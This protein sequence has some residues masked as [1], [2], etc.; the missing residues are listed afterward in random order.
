MPPT[1]VISPDSFKGSLSARAVAAAIADGWRQV[2]PDDDLVLLP[3][4]DGG[5]GTIDAVESAVAGCR[6]RAVAAVTGPDGRSVPGEWLELPD[7]TAVLEIAQ[8]SGLP[9]MARLDALAATSRGLG[10]V[11]R[12]ALDAGARRMVI[13]LGGSASTDAGLG[14]LGALG[15]LATDEQNEPV[16]DGGGWLHEIVTIDRTHLTAPP[17]DGVTLLT[18]VTAPLTGPHGAAAVFGPQKGA[19]PEQ[20]ALLDAGLGHVARILGG[21]PDAPGAG[22]AGG[23][24]YGLSAAWGAH[25]RP[26]ADYLLELGGVYDAIARADL[27]ITGE[28]SFDEQ[29]LGGKLVGQVLTL[30]GPERTA[31][32]AGRVAARTDAWTASLTALAGSAESAMADT[33]RW[34]KAAGA[35]AAE[36]FSA[37]D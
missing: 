9:L 27:V 20:V 2:R 15:L 23:A 8:A 30:A 12:A 24:A 11:A 6:R 1:I 25:I 35:A 7:G 31:V 13:G 22:A 34:A 33:T 19:T 5:E 17:P 4:A 10:E 18:D 3:L 36:A 37:R 29:S 28:G 32:I 26:G 21:D 16:H 14:A